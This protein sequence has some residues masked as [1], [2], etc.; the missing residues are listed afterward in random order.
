MENI[1]A[2]LCA[3]IEGD[4]DA[5]GRAQIEKHLQ[6][7]PGHKKLLQ[8]LMAMRDLVR[9]LPRV[10]APMDVGESLRQKV[11]RSMLLDDGPALVSEPGRAS[12]WP[13][14]FGIAAVVMLFASLC[15]IVYKALS[16]TLKPA[17][18][19]QDVAIIPAMPAPAK[20]EIAAP[21]AKSASPQTPAPPAQIAAPA[22]VNNFVQSLQQAQQTE[23]AVLDVGGIRRRLADFGYDV[24]PVANSENG[25]V[26][27]PAGSSPILMVVNSTD[28]LATRLQI[29]Q[30]LTNSAGVSW[31]VVP[32]DAQAPNKPATRPSSDT[33]Q[34]GFALRQVEP[35]KSTVAKTNSA[36]PGN[37]TTQPSAAGDLYV[38]HGLDAE[39]A[40]ALRQ[41]LIVPQ[42]GSEVQVTMQPALDLVTTQPSELLAKDTAIASPPGISAP[43]ATQPAEAAN[44]PAALPAPAVAAPMIQ[45]QNSVTS[46]MNTA[47]V[48]HEIDAVIVL[49]PATMVPSETV[50]PSPA[51]PATQP[52]LQNIPMEIMPP[53][54]QPAPAT[55][56]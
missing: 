11:E 47:P 48:L 1:E 41:S 42:N 17:V 53:T 44:S 25:N 37:A 54:T 14:F 7:N 12:R 49:N 24:E 51:V 40:D 15:F 35:D 31:G 45:A 4:L 27:A 33:A 9:N 13:Q 26:S 50:A 23:S 56:P 43:A 3:F 2:M 36:R 32:A 19:T 38:A 22:P 28:P 5:T 20:T 52:T 30:F 6:D 18:F 39:K 8:E 29:R 34:I 21:M 46:P 16:P 55:Q 10:K